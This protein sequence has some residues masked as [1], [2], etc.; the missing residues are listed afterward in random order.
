M[1]SP[2]TTRQFAVALALVATLSGI[3][4]ASMETGRVTRA[5]TATPAADWALNGLPVLPE[6]VVTAPRLQA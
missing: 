5:T 1:Y 2:S 4:A 3:L 6:I